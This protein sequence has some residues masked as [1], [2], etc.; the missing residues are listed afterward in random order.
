MP[1]VNC[2]VDNCEYW[3]DGNSCQATQIVIQNDED[4]GF[5]PTATLSSLTPTPADAKDDTCCQTFK[6]K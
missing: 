1:N 4:G 6:E 3:S 5:P 2:T